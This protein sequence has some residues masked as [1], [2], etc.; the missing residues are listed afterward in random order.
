VHT[1]GRDELAEAPAPLDPSVAHHDLIVVVPDL[2]GQPGRLAPAPEAQRKAPPQQRREE[3]DLT[4]ARP[5]SPEELAR[6]HRGRVGE[7]RLAAGLVQLA[8]GAGRGNERLA[9]AGLELLAEAGLRKAETASAWQALFG[10]AVAF[11]ALDGDERGDFDYGPER[12]L[13]GIESRT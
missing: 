2:V 12:L 9:K 3:H 7:D 13:D 10:Y 8:I 6:G 11:P 5:G 1:V 4:V